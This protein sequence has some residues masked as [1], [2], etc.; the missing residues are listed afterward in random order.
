MRI[1]IY[2]FFL[3]AAP[4][5]GFAQTR[6]S[7]IA[8]TSCVD[9]AGIA[10]Y[11]THS[12]KYQEGYEMYQSYFELCALDPESFFEF[13]GIGSAN[14]FRKENDMSRFAEF[15]GWLK[16]VLYYNPDE[17]YYCADVGQM[18]QT[19]YWF[20]STRGHDYLGAIAVAQYLLDAKKCDDSLNVVFLKEAIQEE[21]QLHLQ[22]WR[23]TVQDSLKTPLDTTLP[24]LEDLG[25][26]ILRGPNQGA[27]SATHEPH[28]G[29]LIA[30]RNPF[31]DILGLKYRLDKSA[32]V[33]I[34]VYDLLGRS[35][36]SEGQ[37]Y[38]TEGE[39]ALSLQS[40]GWSSGSYYVRLSSPSG[41]VKTVKVVKE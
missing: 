13:N 33:R 7:V 39:H 38:K 17:R 40:K 25:L 15:R 22:K 12:G 41:E 32:M 6:Q 30:V 8:D 28:L 2:I 23:D 14:S 5:V 34:A 16:K 18:F 11:L 24:S 4:A 29:E 31:T 35:V 19:F 1:I 9:R 27:V 20:D 36:Y 21:Y 3:C 10:Y 26:G 37:G